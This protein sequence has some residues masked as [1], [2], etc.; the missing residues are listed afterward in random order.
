MWQGWEESGETVRNMA[1]E[2]RTEP[3]K[4]ARLR[5]GPPVI[6]AGYEVPAEV[7]SVRGREREVVTRLWIVRLLEVERGGL[8]LCIQASGKE[9]EEAGWRLMQQTGKT[10]LA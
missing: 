9:K 4:P 3:A 1:S 10:R 5:Q 7:C 6:A 2:Q 8:F